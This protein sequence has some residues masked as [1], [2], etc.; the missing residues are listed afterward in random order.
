MTVQPTKDVLAEQLRTELRGLIRPA[1]PAQAERLVAAA[2]REARPTRPIRAWGGPL[3]AAMT[4]AIAATVTMVVAQGD[5]SD[6]RP[7]G[8][9]GSA[10]GAGIT[11]FSTPG[12]QNRA[13]VTLPPGANTAVQNQVQD[14]A[15]ALDA[16]AAKNFT[17]IYGGVSLAEAGSRILVH[18]TRL[19][20]AVQS[21]L[22]AYLPNMPLTFKQI[23]TTLREQRTTRDT[24]SAAYPSLLAQGFQLVSANT[25]ADTGLEVIKIINPT[26]A[27]VTALTRQFGPHLSIQAVR[28]S[29]QVRGY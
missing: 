23:A 19:D 1:D 18:L 17:D 28:P 11:A 2:Q 9:Q 15:L 14:A 5:G 8:P 10:N 13:A 16:H 7:L 21:A 24:V 22:Q 6:T 4:V 12:K 25:D 20:P 29:A 26:S 27:Q 3:V